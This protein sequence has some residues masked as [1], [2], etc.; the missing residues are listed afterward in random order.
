MITMREPT[1]AEIEVIS[2]FWE[3]CEQG[4]YEYA[5]N[6]RIATVGNA[7][8]EAAYEE[9]QAGGCCGYFDT[10]ME[11]L[12]GKEFRWGFNYGH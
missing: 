2:K 6:F 3:G 9:V 12:D 7:E 11:T 8:E 5:D 4:D 1:E 10:V